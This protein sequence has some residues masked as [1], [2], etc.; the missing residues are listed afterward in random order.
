MNAPE[1]PAS[2]YADFRT[3]S[4]L[5]ALRCGHGSNKCAWLKNS[6]DHSSFPGTFHER[7]S[8]S[9]LAGSWGKTS[10]EHRAFPSSGQPVR[11]CPTAG[12]PSN[13]IPEHQ[14][15]SCI[16]FA[17]KQILVVLAFVGTR[18]DLRRICITNVPADAHLGARDW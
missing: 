9:Q 15:R 3:L 6:L 7:F 5:G 18:L 4:R 2:A 1:A 14:S 13:R 16:K 12:L 8:A 11:A 10:G 17:R